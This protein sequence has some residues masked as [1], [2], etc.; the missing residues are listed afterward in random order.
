M[1]DH[2]R[3]AEPQAGNVSLPV[4]PPVP[5]GALRARA[6]DA[7]G[8]SGR[9]SPR[10]H[11]LCPRRAPSGAAAQPRRLAGDAA[12]PTGVCS[13]AAAP[14]LTESRRMGLRT[15]LVTMAAFLL[16]APAAGAFT[17]RGSVEQVD[18]TGV[19][20]GARVTLLDRKGHRVARQKAGP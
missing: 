13:P 8:R 3:R 14:D 4:L 2:P 11:G 7:R 15:L 20:K 19:H 5:P 1:V 10:A 12:G 9:A 17:A 16:M 6:R 18:V